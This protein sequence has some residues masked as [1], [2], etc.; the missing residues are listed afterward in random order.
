M[1]DERK[2][3]HKSRTIRVRIFGTIYLYANNNNIYVQI[4]SDLSKKRII[5]K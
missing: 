5:Y 4:S 2:D 3:Q 1:W